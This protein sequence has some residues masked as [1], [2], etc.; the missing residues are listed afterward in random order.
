MRQHTR[1]RPWRIQP[2]RSGETIDA[3]SVLGR[4]E[5][6][7]HGF[8]RRPTSEHNVTVCSSPHNQRCIHAGNVAFR[9]AAPGCGSAA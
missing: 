4:A 7:R 9:I 5:G 3:G 2:S 8:H 1:F 6:L